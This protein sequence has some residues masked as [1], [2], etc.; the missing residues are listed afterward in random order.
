VLGDWQPDLNVAHTDEAAVQNVLEDSVVGATEPEG[1]KEQSEKI[2]SKRF[3]KTYKQRVIDDWHAEE[4]QEAIAEVKADLKRNWPAYALMGALIITNWTRIEAGLEFATE[5]SLKATYFACDNVV[6][7][8]PLLR[9]WDVCSTINPMEQGKDVS[10]GG[11]LS[12][13]RAFELSQSHYNTPFY[14]SNG[15]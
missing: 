9:D 15:Q 6:E 1:R 12:G 13:S 8:A 4:N 2:T 3:W 11:S 14:D 5:Q 10:D 7:H